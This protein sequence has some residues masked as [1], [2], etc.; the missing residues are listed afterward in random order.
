ML[1]R[2][3]PVRIRPR[4]LQQPVARAQAAL[5]RRDAA[6]VLGIDRQ[7]QPVEK[8]APLRGRPDE[9]LIHRR[10]QPDHAQMVGE[11][12]RRADRLAVDAAFARLRAVSSPAGGS[13]PVPSVASPSAP[14]ISAETAQE[15]SPSE[16]APR[17]SVARRKPRPGARKRNRLDQIGLA[18]AVRARQHHQVA[19]RSR[20]LPRDSCGNSSASGGG[21]GR[22]SC[23]Q[24]AMNRSVRSH[25]RRE[26]RSSA[27]RARRSHP[28]RHQ[29][30]ERALGVLVLDQRRRAGIGE[31][32]HRH[33]ALDLRGDVEQVARVEADIERIGSRTRPRSPRWRCRNPG[34]SPTASACRR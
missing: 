8:A 27:A 18:G 30:V 6:G 13:M 20:G 7:H 31:L 4:F 33:L 14:S 10:R 21:C 9:Q 25:R 16:S 19:V 24:H 32:E 23:A 11:G 22:Q 3:E 5:Q 29:H 15:P 26:L 28:H 2:V 17:H 1:D 34:W 12:G